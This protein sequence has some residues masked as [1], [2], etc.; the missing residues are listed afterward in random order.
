MLPIRPLQSFEQLK[1]LADPRRLAILRQL[2]AG[3]ASLTML[4]K[5]LGEHPAWVRHPG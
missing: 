2:M 4:G 3:P 1:L 5:V